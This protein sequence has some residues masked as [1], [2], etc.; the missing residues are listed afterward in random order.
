[1]ELVFIGGGLFILLLMTG[2]MIAVLILNQR[3]KNLHWLAQT[4]ALTNVYNRSGFDQV[5]DQHIEA[6][7]NSSFVVAEL[8]IDNFK[9]INDM[10]GHAAGDLALQSL[11]NNMRK[12]FLGEAIIGRNGGDEFCLLL[13]DTTCQSVQKKIRKIHQD[14]EKFCL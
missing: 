8:D 7:A 13:P 4:D 12:A 9:F 10:Y 2:L 14:K 1:M 3:R 11:T 6:H 5:L